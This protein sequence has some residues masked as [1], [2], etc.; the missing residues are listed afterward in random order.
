MFKLVK[1]YFMPFYIYVVTK[2]LNE[3]KIREIPIT[4]SIDEDL[5]L[6]RKVDNYVSHFITPTPPDKVIESMS[7][8]FKGLTFL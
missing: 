2:E 1:E 6:A 5:L 4:T 8:D 7:P 3:Y